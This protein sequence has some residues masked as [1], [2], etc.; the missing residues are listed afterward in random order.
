[1]SGGARVGKVKLLP[2]RMLI[3]NI[4]GNIRGVPTTAS[5]PSIC[6]ATPRPFYCCFWEPQMFNRMLYARSNSS[7]IGAKGIIG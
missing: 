7:T 5:T 6:P 2:G 1:M 3:A 4:K